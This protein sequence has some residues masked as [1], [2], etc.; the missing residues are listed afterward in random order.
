MV[1]PHIG[2]EHL[3]TA[4]TFWDFIRWWN[5][6]PVFLVPLAIIAAL[7]IRGLILLRGRTHD[8]PVTPGRTVCFAAGFL[9]LFLALVSPIDV[10]A[11]ERFFIHM[12]QHLLFTLVAAPLLLLSNSMPVFLWS[13]PREVRQ[14]LGQLVEREGPL[15]RLLRFLTIP[16][17]A[18]TLHVGTMWA[19]HLPGAYQAALRSDLVH[20]VMHLSMFGTAV[21]FWWVVIGPAPVRSQLSYPARLLYVFLGSLQSTAL[22]AIITFTTGIMYHYYGE[23]PEHWGISTALDQQLAGLIMWIPAGMM[24]LIAL[25]ILFFLW[26]GREERATTQP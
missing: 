3:P 6:D 1:L 21:L 7:Y 24:Y 9:A 19:W 20:I 4:A 10:Y 26:A 16:A 25:T 2:D 22:G 17:I 23:A 14:S 13:F 12:I 11:Q 5:W 8:N 15:R 18:W